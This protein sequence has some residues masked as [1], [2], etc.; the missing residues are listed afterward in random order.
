MKNVLGT[1]LLLVAAGLAAAVEPPTAFFG[2]SPGTDHRLVPYDR[3]VAYARHLAGESPRIQV[4]SLGK[5]TLGREL[6]MVAVSAEQ[7]LAR[8]DQIADNARKINRGEANDEGAGQIAS[9]NP[10]I[11]AVTCSLHASE[12]GASQLAPLL[13]HRLAVEET[14]EAEAIRAQVVLLLFPS[15]NPDGQMMEVEWNDRQQNTAYEGT[16]APGLYHWYAGHDNN[17]DWF[18]RSLAETRLVAK[19]LYSRY[20]PQLLVDLHQMGTDGDR[21]FLPP[22]ADPPT[23]GLHPLTWRAIH[24]IASHVA[25]AMEQQKLSGVASRGDF[26]GW[27]IGSLDD[28]AWFHNVPSLLYETASVRLASPVFV[29]PEEISGGESPRNEPRMFSP[30]PWPGGWWRLGDIVNYE[31]VATWSALSAAAKNR[32]LLLETVWQ[33]ARAQIERGHKEKPAGFVIPAG[34]HDPSTARQLVYTLIEA[35]IEVFQT[36]EAGPAEGRFHSQSSYYVPLAQPYRAFVKNLL[37][38]QRYP[39]LRRGPTGTR[40]APYDGAGWS[41]SHGMGVEVTALMSPLPLAMKRLTGDDMLRSLLPA[42]GEDTLVLDPR[43]NDA[44]RAV[45]ALLARGIPI[46]RLIGAQDNLPAGT[47]FAP[48]AK[49]LPVLREL[50]KRGLPIEASLRRGVPDLTRPQPAPRIG[51]FQTWRGDSAEGWLRFVLDEHNIH[52]RT[53]KADE[54]KGKDSLKG[55]N[56]IVF[57]GAT[58]SQIDAGLPPKKWEK[59]TT[60]LP[61]EFSGGIG[62]EGQKRLEEF[63]AGGGLLLFVGDSCDYAIDK[64]KLPV[65]NLM[66]EGERGS[67]FAEVNCPGSYLRF[68]SKESPLTWGLPESGAIYYDNNPVFATRP[69]RRADESRST[70][71]VFA[72]QDL[73][74]SGWLDGEAAL[75]RRALVVD[76]RQGKGRVILIGPDPIHRTH[77]GGTYKLLFNALLAV[78]SD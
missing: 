77:S 57:C 67:G 25:L 59:W 60:P 73:L 46:R 10:V 30:N 45:F 5:T 15:V 22:Y 18:R 50:E 54:F 55:F 56:V 13:M 62:S 19:T 35:G 39:D 4:I 28:S 23:P 11:V 34:Q 58:A 61:P 69:P 38:S 3:I 40:E 66:T 2:F 71:L 52:F 78:T 76:Y 64:L 1:L 7:N 20:Y 16:A 51:V 48:A 63:L 12:I 21:F 49:A 75:L 47:F 65:T 6:V 36:T 8:L 43:R 32:A 29:E 17:R 53:L 41:L 14:V 37:E 68:T 9:T 44:H 33:T 70:P 26:T 42:Q 72:G 74:L 27:W 31:M 24:V